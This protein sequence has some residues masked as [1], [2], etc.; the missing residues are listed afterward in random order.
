MK[1]RFAAVWMLAALI[2]ASGTAGPPSPANCTLP[3]HILLVGAS[4]GVPDT[5]L[6]L[7]EI[8]VRD[9]ANVPEPDRLVE[10]RFLN[11]PGARVAADQLQAAVSSKCSTHGITGISGADGSVR[12]TAVGG[13]D[14]TAG[15]G[16]GGCAGVY[17]GGV[18][19]GF[20][21]VAYLDEDGAY[22]LGAGDLSIWLS[23]F[24]T[25]D[26]IGRSDFDG[27]GALGAMDVSLW[28]TVWTSGRQTKSATIYCP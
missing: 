7:F 16:M 25:G 9:L 17:A 4:Y 19:L 23:D 8:V 15:H 2:P 5:T 27:D 6:G 1:R 28:L 24:V 20:V 11:C 22:G 26:P 10:V 13:G 21:S 18:L 3:G 14:P 12:M